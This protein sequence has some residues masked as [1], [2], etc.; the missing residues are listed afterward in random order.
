[1]TTTNRRPP[2][3]EKVMPKEGITVFTRTKRWGIRARN[4]NFAAYEHKIGFKCARGETYRLEK[5]GGPGGS[6]VV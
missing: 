3:A 5:T 1:M 4:A 6:P 2:S